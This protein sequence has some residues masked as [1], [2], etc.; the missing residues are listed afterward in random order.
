MNTEPQEPRPHRGDGAALV[1]PVAQEPPAPNGHPADHVHVYERD[2]GQMLCRHCGATQPPAPGSAQEPADPPMTV[3]RAIQVIAVQVVAR[4][5][6]GY[7]DWGDY[8]D[9]GEGDWDAIERAVNAMVPARA[10]ADFDA[11]Y[12]LLKA[13]ADGAES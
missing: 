6:D 2:Y 9:V 5:I 4:A 13:R 7:C 12:A 3:E 1:T 8:P 11:A 10:I